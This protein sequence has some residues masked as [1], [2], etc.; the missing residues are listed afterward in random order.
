MRWGGGG[1]GIVPILK[2]TYGSL[3]AEQLHPKPHDLGGRTRTQRLG[4]DHSAL[5]AA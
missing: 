4:T 3:R 2:M 5:S 1:D